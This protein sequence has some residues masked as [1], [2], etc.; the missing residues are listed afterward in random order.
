[1]TIERGATLRIAV[2]DGD[3]RLPHARDYNLDSVSGR[4]LHLVEALSRHSGATVAGQGKSVWFE[5]DW[6]EAMVR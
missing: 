5:L 2:D 6:A 3:P 4:G 1:V